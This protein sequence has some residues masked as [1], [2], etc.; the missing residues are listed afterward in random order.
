MESKKKIAV[1]HPILISGGAESLCLYMVEA[2]VDDYD[3]TIFTLFGYPVKQLD[4]IYGTNL[5]GKNLKINYIFPPWMKEALMSFRPSLNLRQ[6][7]LLRHYKRFADDFDLSIST[8]NEMD[9]GRKG[10]QYIHNPE[11]SRRKKQYDLISGY[12]EERMKHNITITISRWS[13]VNIKRIYSIDA[14]VIYPPVPSDFPPVAWDKRDNGFVCAGRLSTDKRLDRAVEVIKKVR[15]KGHDVHLHICGVGG[16][17]DAEAAIRR[18]QR[19]NSSWLFLHKMLNRSEYC[20]LLAGHK[21]GLHMKKR[22]DFGIV[23]AEMVKAGCVIFV[24]NLG[25]QMEI[26][27]GDPSIIFCS[28]ED[29]VKKITYV[30]D[31]KAAQKEIRMRLAGQAGL[32]SAEKFKKEIREFVNG[33]FTGDLKPKT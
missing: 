3:V 25:G 8:Y 13:A 22:E 2:L 9:F 4:E 10:I 17:K 29:L 26:V 18:L 23:V 6:N 28:E 32:F 14:A 21:Y 33:Y 16:Q 11:Y 20:E 1:L 5:C 24:S 19:E 7:V 30:L 12:D 15:E 31:N 27:G